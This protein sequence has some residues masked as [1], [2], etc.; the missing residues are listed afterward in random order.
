MTAIVDYGMGNIKSVSNMLKKIG[1]ATTVTSDPDVLAKA[2]R[3]ILPGVGS[4]DAG[5]K[6]LHERSLVEVLSRRVLDYGVPILGICLGMQLFAMGSEEGKCEGLG[7]LDAHVERF[8]MPAEALSLKVPH[9]GWNTIHPLK[10]HV[11]F[12]DVKQ[13]MRFYHVHSYHYQR[14]DDRYVVATTRYGYDFPVVVARGN[15]MGVQFH[16]EK[17]HQYGIQLLKNFIEAT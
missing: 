10:D 11:L 1:V 5:M 17:S 15:I 9:M 13:P 12:R 2:K 16:P 8:S 3:I 14:Y 7:W 4:F 6:N